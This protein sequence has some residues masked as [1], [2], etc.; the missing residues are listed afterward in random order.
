[1]LNSDQVVELA[2][3]LRERLTQLGINF[4]PDTLLDGVPVHFADI[5]EGCIAYQSLIHDPL[6]LSPT[7]RKQALLLTEQMDHQLY[8]HLPYHLKHLSK[9]IHDVTKG[10]KAPRRQAK[11]VIDDGSVILASSRPPKSKTK[12]LRRA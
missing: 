11:K 9:A 8:E 7:E 1:M 10:L 12:R 4:K 5:Y 6:K 2:T 3:N